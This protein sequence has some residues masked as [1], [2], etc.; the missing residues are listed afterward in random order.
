VGGEIFRTRP[1]RPWGPPTHFHNAWPKLQNIYEKFKND[2]RKWRFKLMAGY[3]NKISSLRLLTAMQ[4]CV[5][6][7]GLSNHTRQQLL[8]TP[9][10]CKPR[11][12]TNRVSARF[13]S[14]VPCSIH[15]GFSI[16]TIFIIPIQKVLLKRHEKKTPANSQQRSALRNSLVS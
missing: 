12:A 15:Y 7:L 11:F 4:G 5:C 6:T 14:H 1:D 16:T 9:R 2:K 10:R 8:A 13:C 3:Y